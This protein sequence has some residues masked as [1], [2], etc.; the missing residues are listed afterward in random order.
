VQSS[1][2]KTDDTE[3][4]ALSIWIAAAAMLAAQA[5]TLPSREEAGKAAVNACI[6]PRDEVRPF[7][8]F[9]LAERL[10]LIACTQR[11][12]AAMLSQRVPVHIDD[13]TT[14]I[15]ATA[16]GVALTYEYSVTLDRSA[17]GSASDANVARTACA[18]PGMATAIAAG[19]VYRYIWRD[20]SGRVLHRLTVDRCVDLATPL[21]VA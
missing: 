14:L 15:A 2:S 5:G 12:A 1:A 13:D 20:R 11:V 3:E 16:S 7:A 17:F 10:A 21:P 6:S 9:S 18:D 19:G 8:S 4:F